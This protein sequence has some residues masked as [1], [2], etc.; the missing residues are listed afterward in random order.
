MILIRFAESSIQ[1]EAPTNRELWHASIG[2]IISDKAERYRNKN[3]VKV[4]LLVS[5]DQREYR[6]YAVVHAAAFL[7]ILQQHLLV[8]GK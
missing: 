8:T 2:I 4:G 3:C 1:I 6:H 7:H 5:A